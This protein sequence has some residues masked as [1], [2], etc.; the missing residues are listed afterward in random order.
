M[1]PKEIKDAVGL[2]YLIPIIRVRFDCFNYE[3]S[4]ISGQFIGG[5]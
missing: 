3:Q 4:F 5:I 2:K 1:E